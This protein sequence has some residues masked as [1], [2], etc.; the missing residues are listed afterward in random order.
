MADVRE[1]GR[2]MDRMTDIMAMDPDREENGPQGRRGKRSLVL[3]A[4]K[5]R[6]PTGEINVRL[7]NLSRTGALLEAEKMPTVATEV[8]FERGDTRVPARVAW[9]SEGRFGLEFLEQIEESE[10]L[11]HV[12][13]PSSV[14]PPVQ[15]PVIRRSGFR[16]NALS[17]AEREIAADWVKPAGRVLD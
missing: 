5:V 11:V 15:A 8:T 3:L 10:V 1:T 2:G 14:R 6:T 12:G 9:V 16:G 4:A 13:R 7:R 17:Q